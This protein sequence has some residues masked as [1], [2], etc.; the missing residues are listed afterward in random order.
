M[1]ENLFANLGQWQWVW[2]AWG[3]LILAYAAYV[4]YLS[5]RRARLSKKEV[6]SSN[7]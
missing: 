3:E 7:D 4:A 2:I 1:F 5:W 6:E